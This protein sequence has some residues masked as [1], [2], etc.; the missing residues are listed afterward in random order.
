MLPQLELPD[1]GMERSAWSRVAQARRV[2]GRYQAALAA[3]EQLE[4][5]DQRIGADASMLEGTRLI[6][7]ANTL[8][9]V[10]RPLDALERLTRALELQGGDESSVP[11]APLSTLADSSAWRWGCVACS[12]WTLLERLDFSTVACNINRAA[13]AS[14][15][16]APCCCAARLR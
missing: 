7:W 8:K 6:N 3:Y 1:L 9:T 4:R 13:T 14:S 10:G 16:P 11:P 2:A 5:V 12:A 15:W